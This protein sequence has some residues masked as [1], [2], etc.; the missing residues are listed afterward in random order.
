[1][2]YPSSIAAVAVAFAG[3]EDVLACREPKSEVADV[4]VRFQLAHDPMGHGEMASRHSMAHLQSEPWVL[5]KMILKTPR[6]QVGEA[7]ETAGTESESVI[8]PEMEVL[9]DFELVAAV[10]VGSKAV[11]WRSVEQLRQQLV[12]SGRKVV[13]GTAAAARTVAAKPGL[14]FAH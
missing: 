4:K 8:A 9:L 3:K 1:M 14:D 7:D 12:G 10:A 5:E 11:A 13:E 6:T 2:K